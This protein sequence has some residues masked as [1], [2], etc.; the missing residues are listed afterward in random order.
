[1][2]FIHSYIVS[3]FAFALLFGTINTQKAKAQDPHFSQNYAT[4]IFINP[5][6]TGLMNGDLRVAAVY[7]NQWSSIMPSVPFRTIT[8]SAEMT[9]QGL[10]YN[11]RVAFGLMVYNDKA[12]DVAFTTNYVDLALAYNMAINP[13][14]FVSLGVEGGFKQTGFDLEKA[15]F[16]DQYDGDTGFDP[17]ISTGETFDKTSLIRP[18]LAAGFMFYSA[19]SSRQNFY[20]G[21]GMYHFTRSN[22]AFLGTEPDKYNAKISAQ[23]GASLPIGKSIDVVPSFYYIK[24]GTYN[25]IELGSFIRF[26]FSTD[27]QTQL[28]KAFNLG[29][30]VRVG[31]HLDGFGLN[32]V[33]L[34]TKIDYNEFT[35]GLSYD[36]TMGSLAA[37]N[38]GRGGGEI[39][40]IYTSDLRPNKREPLY[41]PRF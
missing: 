22:V 33:V 41:C 35:L 39:A 18:N 14:T 38:A 31:N 25:K 28:D 34:A 16:E 8:A 17:T 15:Q 12:G 1:M 4:P 2:K 27:R 26:I 24:Q 19:P 40:L 21:M 23:V 3:F 11:D 6:M 32:T 37:A 7:R 5:A 36:L 30:F 10:A 20:A 29:A 13:T 9:T